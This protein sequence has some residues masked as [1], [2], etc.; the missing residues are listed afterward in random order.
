V[1]QEV[2][3]FL[4]NAGIADVFGTEASITSRTVNVPDRLTKTL[5]FQAWTFMIKPLLLLP[6][7]VGAVPKRLTNLQL[8]G[9]IFNWNQHSR[10]DLRHRS[11]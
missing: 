9:I 3:Y 1:V 11:L 6:R 4:E 2:W 8:E 5:A 7:I 10:G